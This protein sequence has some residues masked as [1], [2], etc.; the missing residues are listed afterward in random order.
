M[1]KQWT[2]DQIREFVKNDFQSVAARMTKEMLAY[3]DVQHELLKELKDSISIYGD[4]NHTVTDF[5]DRLDEILKLP[6]I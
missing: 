5:E 6:I 2:I 4:R 1:K 3:Y